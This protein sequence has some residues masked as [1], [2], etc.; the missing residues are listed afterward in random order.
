VEEID[1]SNKS[2]FNG[3]IFALDENVFEELKYLKKLNLADNQIETIDSNIFDHF[4]DFNELNL[5][6]NKLKPINGKFF[7]DLGDVQAVSFFNNP[8]QMDPFVLFKEIFDK[9]SLNIQPL[10]KCTNVYMNYLVHNQYIDCGKEK[11]RNC[12]TDS[13]IDSSNQPTV[14][15][16]IIQ[17]KDYTNMVLREIF[18]LYE[19]EKKRLE[20]DEKLSTN[21]LINELK[22]YKAL[23]DRDDVYILNQMLENVD[24][25]A[26]ISGPNSAKRS[27]ISFRSLKELFF[28]A[29]HVNKSKILNFLLEFTKSLLDIYFLDC[30]QMNIQQKEIEKIFKNILQEDMKLNWLFYETYKME[31]WD[32]ISLILD[33]IKFLTDDGVRKYFF[34]ALE[35]FDV[36]EKGE[37]RLDSKEAEMEM[38]M[39]KKKSILQPGEV[40][41]KACEE[42]EIM[43]SRAQSIQSPNLVVQP[44]GVKSHMVNF[45]NI[46]QAP[47]LKLPNDNLKPAFKPNSNVQKSSLKEDFEN[48]FHNKIY[49]LYLISESRQ[50]KLLRHHTTQKFLQTK[51]E[52]LGKYVYNCMLFFYLFFLICYSINS[53]IVFGQIECAQSVKLIFSILAFICPG[54]FLLLEIVQLSLEGFKFF[55]SWKNITEILN[56]SFCIVSIWMSE[57]NMKL[58]SGFYSI[59]LVLSFL[60]FI[61]KLE[62]VKRWDIGLYVYAFKNI[63]RKS[64][65]LTMIVLVLITGFLL[66]FR[67]QSSPKLTDSANII[68][69]NNSN[70]FFPID[71]LKFSIQ[72]ASNIDQVEENQIS[73]DNLANYLVT[74]LFMFVMHMFLFNL[75]VGIA[76]EE[77]ADVLLDGEIK[78]IQLRIEYVIRVQHFKETLNSKCLRGPF[79]LQNLNFKAKLKEMKQFNLK[80]LLNETKF[81]CFKLFGVYYF[82]FESKKP[83]ETTIEDIKDLIINSEKDLQKEI[84]IIKEELKTIKSKVLNNA[85]FID[86]L[87]SDLQRRIADLKEHTRTEFKVCVNDHLDNL[88]SASSTQK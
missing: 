14:I 70:A 31:W 21:I 28:Y 29:I 52:M 26:L 64:I 48:P 60:L 76:I 54:I 74:F 30:M 85:S 3:G 56:Y 15:D 72:F 67:L 47:I 12:E 24:Y 17:D 36:A 18:E 11:A 55:H 23:I 42:N 59:T 13:P 50:K 46:I 4:I 58:K 77:L 9:N 43:K 7:E 79:S 73:Y 27:T 41:L 40:I 78:L 81:V 2:K 5:S 86:E 82:Q 35:S 16:M 1:L 71:L 19:T 20:G 87:N 69:L 53:E 75:F 66:T 38:K 44:N 10:N 25:E 68:Q 32:T 6:N 61:M 22:T 49:P 83:R 65:R 88:K 63:F 45:A 8:E 39:L 34:D 84:E 33:L 37:L 51:W 80:Y 62:K 57:H